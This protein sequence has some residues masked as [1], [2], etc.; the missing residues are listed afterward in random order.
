LTYT[1]QLHH[2]GIKLFHGHPSDGITMLKKRFLLLSL[3]IAAPLHSDDEPASA[4]KPRQ[5]QPAA[6]AMLTQPETKAVQPAS[7]NAPASTG[8]Q[9]VPQLTAKATVDE[10][11]MGPDQA[12][13]IIPTKMVADRYE[14]TIGATLPLK[15]SEVA[16][17]GNEIF[18]GMSLFFNKFQKEQTGQ[19]FCCILN[20]LDDRAKVSKIRQ[21]ITELTKQTPLILSLFGTE[22]VSSTIDAIAEG[23]FF[24]VF[25]IEGAPMFRKPEYKNIVYYRASDAEELSALVTYA[26]KT[27]NKKRFSLFYE[28]SEWGESCL[29]VLKTILRSHNLELVAQGSYPQYTLNVTQA[30]TTIANKEPSVIICVAH[31]RPAYNFICQI[32]NRGLYN[33]TIL[34]ISRLVT[35]QKTLR[36]ARG[37]GAD[38][39]ITASVVPNPRTSKLQIA[40]EYRQTLAQ[41]AANKSPSTFS[42]EG[43]INAALLT[44][45]LKLVHPPFTVEKLRSIMEKLHR[46]RFKGLILNFN[47]DTRTLAY[48]LKQD[49]PPVWFNI[50]ENVE[51][52]TAASL[53][54]KKKS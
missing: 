13:T 3:L 16:L 24:A 45:C 43:Y 46:I 11:E 21:N 49:K 40:Q 1:Q 28:A 41:Y 30:A 7:A 26:I 23:Q 34:G 35:I 15:G 50:G 8:K 29:A 12:G 19:R 33:T 44:E 20:A 17:L 52:P 5:D 32:L 54:P 36:E 6:K 14:I 48:S 25:P 53:N 37:L 47:P 2:L 27:L 51:W 42:F 18:D 9:T 39:F 31:A 10:D 38:R 4:T 22:T